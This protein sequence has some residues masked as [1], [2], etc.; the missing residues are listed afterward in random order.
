MSEIFLRTIL[1]TAILAT[2]SGTAIADEGHGHQHSAMALHDDVGGT[3]TVGALEISEAF[4]RMTPPAA[5][6][7]RAF[8]NVR[9]NGTDPDRLIAVSSPAAG[10]VVLHEMKMQDKSMQMVEKAGG[11]EIAG[12]EILS[13]SAGGFHHLMFIDIKAAFVEGDRIPVTLTFE[14]AGT[15]DL[16]L[17]VG[18]D[19]AGHNH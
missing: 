9:N 11:M 10:R 3:V 2:F 13:L 17:P 15:V 12:G 8:L 4:T 6:E 19:H 5:V 7:A 14:N 1:A 16:H 18:D